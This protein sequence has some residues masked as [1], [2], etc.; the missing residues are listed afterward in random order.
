MLILFDVDGT[1]ISSHGAG[2]DALEEA[3]RRLHGPAFGAEGIAFAGRIDPV[4]V[5]EMLAANGVVADAAS[6]AALRA[7][8]ARCLARRFASDPC[9]E[10][11][12]GVPELLDALGAD[13][14]VALGILS[15]NFAETGEMKLR[16]AGL[17]PERFAVRAWGS[18]ATRR[19]DLVPIALDRHESMNGNR[20]RHEQVVLIGD[21]E[22]DIACA[23]EHGCRVLAVATGLTALEDLVPLWPDLLLEDLR[24]TP[25]ILSWIFGET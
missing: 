8:Y 11:L 25:G 23:Q 3:G 4:I 17:D 18:D 14:R 7:E 5:D 24:D 22:H 6:R 12:P 16:A 1:L 15:G 13:P 20:L 9:A 19:G 10:A 2:R 21:T